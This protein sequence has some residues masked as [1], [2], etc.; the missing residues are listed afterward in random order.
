MKKVDALDERVLVG[1]L[2]RKRD[3]AILRREHWY[4]M[5]VRKA[6]KRKFG[7]VA[8]YEPARFGK[9]GKRIRY[10]A[11]V[12]RYAVGKRRD[13]L[14][15]EP[16]HPRADEDYKKILVGRLMELPRSIVNVP[17][18]RVSFGFV[19]LK[20]LLAVKN[21]LALYHVAPTEQMVGYA[22]MRAGIR[23]TAQYYVSSGTTRYCLDFAIRCREG[24]IAIECDNQKAHAPARQRKR[25]KAKDHFLR[26]HG[27]RMIRLKE[28]TIVS[29]MGSCIE[30]VRRTVRKL[31]G[32]KPH[33]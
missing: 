32:M 2:K 13:L 28:H 3:L 5:P 9:S 33:H 15:D 22:L 20:D 23:A 18:R 11:R 6:P 16:H 24:R 1:V 10:Y 8:F 26:R 7:Y 29:D 14:P 27:W 12:A 31:G 19:T 17:P 21:I 25:D 30:R 4:R